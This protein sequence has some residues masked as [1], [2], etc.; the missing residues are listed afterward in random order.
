MPTVDLTQS[1][2]VGRR[3]QFGGHDEEVAHL[4]ELSRQSD[5]TPEKS[6]LETARPSGAC[7]IS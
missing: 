1:V 2:V 7:V 4:L 3:K 5:E 6:M